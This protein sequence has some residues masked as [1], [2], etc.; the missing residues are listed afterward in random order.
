MPEI[1]A[2]GWFH[3]VV[4]ILALLTGFYTLV[5]FKVIRFSQPK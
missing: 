4:G 2:F 5:R 3:T 1:T